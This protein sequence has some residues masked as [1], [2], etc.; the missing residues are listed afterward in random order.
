[1]TD[2][3]R[4]APERSSRAALQGVTKSFGATIALDDVTFELRPGEI[5]ALDARIERDDGRRLPRTIVEAG[6]IP[7]R[8][9]PPQVDD[10]SVIEVCLPDLRRRGPP[11]GI[12]PE[13]EAPPVD[14][15]DFELENQPELFAVAMAAVP[16]QTSAIPAI[17]KDRP[18][19]VPVWT[20]ERRHV[21]GIGKQPPAV[22]RPARRQQMIAHAR[23]VD[24]DLV[25]AEL[26]QTVEVR[27][28]RDLDLV[29]ALTKARV[30][31]PQPP[32]QSRP[33]LAEREDAVR[34]LTGERGDSRRRRSHHV[35]GPV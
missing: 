6:E 25:D 30:V 2:P 28:R 21:V 19:G 5:H 27:T 31:G 33:I 15:V 26:S 9:A 18:D 23:T 34:D 11:R 29:G 16:S 22:A 12:R 1:M 10:R 4:P 24:P 3:G 14:E 32:R 17:A 35:Q 13:N 20:Q 8:M 7:A